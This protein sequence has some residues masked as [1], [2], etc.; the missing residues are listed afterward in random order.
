MTKS[1]RDS[2]AYTVC[3]NAG[4]GIGFI[5]PLSEIY[6]SLESLEKASL[7]QARRIS[8]LELAASRCIVSGKCTRGSAKVEREEITLMAQ[9]R[10]QRWGTGEFDTALTVAFGGLGSPPAAPIKWSPACL[11]Q[12]T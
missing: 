7:E 11:R 9:A 4:I 1:E 12:P 2:K 5:G 10:G 8:D 3:R 6:A